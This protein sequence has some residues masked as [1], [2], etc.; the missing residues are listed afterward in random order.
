MNIGQAIMAELDDRF[1]HHG[2]V[3]S[4]VSSDRGRIARMHALERKHGSPKAAA[5]ALGISRE[6][7]RRWGLRK[8]QKGHQAP[9]AANLRRLADAYRNMLRPS[10]LR[11]AARALSPARVK[12][13]GDIRWNGYYNRES[14]RSTTLDPLAL[15]SLVDLWERRDTE[16]LGERF[17]EIASEH[18]QGSIPEDAW[19]GIAIEGD[20]CAFKLL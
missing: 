11:A 20:D 5:A 9:S 18:Y 15:R 2:E 13:T 19:E 6:T 12:V 10:R 14:H 4:P 1:G 16:R 3:I 7:W 8:S 17:Q